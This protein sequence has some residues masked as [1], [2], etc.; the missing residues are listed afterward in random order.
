MEWA[1]LEIIYMVKLVFTC[2]HMMYLIHLECVIK[3]EIQPWICAQLDL[4]IQLSYLFPI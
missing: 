2:N 1:L 4:I 3:T